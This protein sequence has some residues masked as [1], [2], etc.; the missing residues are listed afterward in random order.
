ME[1]DIEFMEQEMLDAGNSFGEIR[2]YIERLRSRNR[3]IGLESNRQEGRV[4]IREDDKSDRS[5][6]EEDED[7]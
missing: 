7:D 5:N 1:E 6:S 4:V 3:D 2:E